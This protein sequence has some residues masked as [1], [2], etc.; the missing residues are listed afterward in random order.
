[1]KQY[2]GAAATTIHA[3]VEQV[4]A[5]LQDV[6]AWP[7]WDA[8]FLNVEGTAA[9]GEQ[10]HLSSALFPDRVVTV[11][12]TE[13][14]PNFRLTLTSGEPEA[15]YQGQ[16]TYI[17]IP[18]SDEDVEFVTY[19]F[20]SGSVPEAVLQA[21]PAITASFRQFAARLKRRAEAPV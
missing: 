4:W 18:K 21:S 2:V 6:S 15:A 9:P 11:R 1:M 5:V 13:F 14:V 16:H 10:V 7:A 17:L 20:F 3:P 19:E 12:V 8:N